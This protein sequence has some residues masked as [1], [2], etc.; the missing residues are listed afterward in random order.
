MF[1]AGAECALG[2]E[3]KALARG[4]KRRRP[5][6]RAGALTMMLLCGAAL[7]NKRSTRQPALTRQWRWRL[8]GCRHP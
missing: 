2:L 6:L 4:A 8:R 7:G 1:T 3:S 5:I